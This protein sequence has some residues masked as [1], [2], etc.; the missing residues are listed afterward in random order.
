MLFLMDGHFDGC[1][2]AGMEG[3][4]DIIEAMLSHKQN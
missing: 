2:S 4:L 3:V 1:H